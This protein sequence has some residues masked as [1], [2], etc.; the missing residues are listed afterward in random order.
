MGPDSEY[1]G[2]LVPMELKGLSTWYR[3]IL[4]PHTCSPFEECSFLVATLGARSMQSKNELQ[5][6]KQLGY[7]FRGKTAWPLFRYSRPGYMSGDLS[8]PQV[9]YLSKALRAVCQVAD[10]VEQDPNY[11][12]DSD[13]K[14]LIPVFIV[15]DNKGSLVLQK[16]WVNIEEAINRPVILYTMNEET[17]NYVLQSTEPGAAWEVDVSFLPVTIRDSGVEYYPRMI[18]IADAASGYIIGQKLCPPEDD[19]TI[20]DAFVNAMTDYGV[21]PKTIYYNRF[22]T[23][24]LLRGIADQLNIEMQVDL[25]LPGISEYKEGLEER[26]LR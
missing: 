13:D 12:Y 23:W 6:I 1:F 9:E 5:R 11:L 25:R 22:N 21:R 19:K 24:S 4:A 3:S 16:G 10:R 15:N 18:I 2:L 20:L 14:S 26:F 17:H 7:R 8:A